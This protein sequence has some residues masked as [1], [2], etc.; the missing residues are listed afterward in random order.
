MNRGLKDN[1]VRQPADWMVR[2][3]DRI[4]EMLALGE[5]RLLF[6]PKMIYSNITLSQN[7]VQTRLKYLVAAGFVEKA[8]SLYRI[9]D[10]GEAYINGQADVSDIEEPKF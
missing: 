8:D 9:T 3:D 6:P 5:Q 2:A 4:L 7:W 1:P 10:L